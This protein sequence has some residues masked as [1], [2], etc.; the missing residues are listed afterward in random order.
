M[1]FHLKFRA[2]QGSLHCA[3]LRGTLIAPCASSA[4]ALGGNSQWPVVAWSNLPD[5]TTRIGVPT[6]FHACDTG[7]ANTASA[8]LI[9][10]K[11]TRQNPNP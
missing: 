5:A 6:E 8:L 7:G 4:P 1:I 10:I 2:F 9:L 3:L 11:T